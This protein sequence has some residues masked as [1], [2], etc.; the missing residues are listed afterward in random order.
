VGGVPT[1]SE[2]RFE[3]YLSA[4]GYEFEKLDAS[5][6]GEKTPDYRVSHAGFDAICEVKEFTDSTLQRF[7]EGGGG[8][9]VERAARALAPV[10]RKIRSAALQL[11]RFEASGLPLAVV[12]AN[13]HQVAVDLSPR[14]IA[15]AMEGDPVFKAALGADG[16]LEGGLAYG[17]RGE[18][19]DGHEHIS[20]IVV[21]EAVAGWEDDWLKARGLQTADWRERAAAVAAAHASGEAPP[22]AHLSATVVESPGAVAGLAVR[23]PAS[24]FDAPQDQWW[25]WC[26]DGRLVRTR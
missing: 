26:K 20:A 3:R 25:S 8:F 11:R 22:G 16:L 10:R 7:V 14:E 24:F 15:L 23:L 9:S 18:L 2:R 4:A 1:A 6:T 17:K 5:T 19:S 13:P 12:L 21:L